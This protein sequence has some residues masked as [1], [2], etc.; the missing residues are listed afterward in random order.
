MSDEQKTISI[1]PAPELVERAFAYFGIELGPE[2]A[3]KVGEK[4]L[5]GLD[6]EAPDFPEVLDKLTGKVLADYIAASMV[7]P[8]NVQGLREALRTVYEVKRRLGSSED[9]E[10]LMEAIERLESIAAN[11]D[12]LMAPERR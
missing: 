5:M 8:S 1:A 2:R 3:L 4:G 9:R 12:G 6:P 10:D 11:L 7:L